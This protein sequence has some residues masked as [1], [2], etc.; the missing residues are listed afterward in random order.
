MGVLSIA[1]VAVTVVVAPL[2]LAIQ[3]QRAKA[4]LYREQRIATAKLAHPSS[5]YYVSKNRRGV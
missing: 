5:G 2:F 4:K 3:H 1:G